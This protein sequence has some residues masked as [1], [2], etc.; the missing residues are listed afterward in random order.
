[1]NS[2]MTLPVSQEDILLGAV[3]KSSKRGHIEKG[4]KTLQQPERL[5]R[6]EKP[7]TAPRRW[8]GQKGRREKGGCPLSAAK[9]SEHLVQGREN[10]ANGLSKEEGEKEAQKKRERLLTP[11]SPAI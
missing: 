5:R 2:P 8:N 9:E 7:S 4:E 3:D 11:R 1:M 10:S 6:K